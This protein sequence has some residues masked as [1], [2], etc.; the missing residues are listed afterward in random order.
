MALYEE[1]VP[2]KYDHPNL[3]QD[4][5]SGQYIDESNGPRDPVNMIQP[6]KTYSLAPAGNDTVH[7]ITA[8]QESRTTPP[9]ENP[10]ALTEREFNRFVE[11]IQWQPDWRTEADKSADYYD[12]NQLDQDTLAELDSRGIMPIIKNL[13][14]PTIDVVLGMEAKTRSDWRVIADTEKFQDVAEGMSQRLHEAERESH[15]DRACSDCFGGQIKAG[16]AWCEVSRHHDPFE[17]TH[18]VRALHRREIYWDWPALDPMLTDARYLIRRRWFD[19]DQAIAF[20]PHAKELIYQSGNGWPADWW[21]RRGIEDASLGFAMDQEIRTSL[22]E[23]EWRNVIERRVVVFECWYRRFVRGHVMNLPNG[24]V[25]EVDMK[26]PVHITLLGSGRVKP[27]P[28]VYSKLR[29][30]F[31]VGPHRIADTEVSR[32]TLP[33]VP[34][35]GYREDLTGI[36]YGLIRSMISPQDEINA[37][38]QKMLWLLSA[39]RLFMDSDALA[40]EYNSFREVLDEIGRADAAVILNPDRKNKDGLSIDDNLELAESQFKVMQENIEAIGNVRGIHNAMMGNE[41]GA[42]SGVAINSLIEQS[43]TV[44]A[45]IMDNYR[46]SRRMVGELLSEQV[47][48]DLTGQPVEILIDGVGA[49]RHTIILNEPAIDE[50]TNLQYIKNDV[51]KSKTKVALED[52]PSTPSYRAQMNTML[53]EVMKSLPPEL[54]AIIAPFYLESTELPKR[55]EIAEAVRK[56]M[57]IMDERNLTPEQKADI[58]RM[59]DLEKELKLRMAL[60]EIGEK[61]AKISKMQAEAQKITAE[62]Q[63]V[64]HGDGADPANARQ[65]QEMVSDL[66][67]QI[68]LLQLQLKNKYEEIAAKVETALATEE[69]KADA[70]I[71]VAHIN[72]TSNE[73]MKGVIDKIADLRAMIHEAKEKKAKSDKK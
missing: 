10:M 70:T 53:A 2:S 51:S 40:K 6:D 20:F 31:W 41:K 43:T 60:A 16:M 52:V 8:Q 39:K 48:Q 27:R 29:R 15:A 68:D 73:K 36:P 11:E 66:N 56:K 22:E 35:W 30:S 9:K 63:E 67:H 55:R 3:R 32:R 59:Q 58:K 69:I 50:Q 13:I 38:A 12:G 18:R 34:F 26:N 72:E 46:D 7:D 44:L 71:E 64:M 57:G 54:Q 45:E 1:G 47:R 4:P 33:Y 37:R 17:Y 25:V 24:D 5:A 21:L 14:Q 62:A 65:M 42:E 61:E 23:W 49:T 19:I 28:A